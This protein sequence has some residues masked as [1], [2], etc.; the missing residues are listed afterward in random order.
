MVELPGPL[1][2]PVFGIDSKIHYK[3]WVDKETGK[4]NEFRGLLGV[5]VNP[6]DNSSFEKEYETILTELFKSFN[7]PKKRSVFKAHDI[8]QLLSPNENAYKSFCL[9]FARK[10]LSLPDTKLTYFVTRINIEHL[11][12]RKVTIFGEYGTATRQVSTQEFI[13]KISPYYN[14]ICA[15]KLG[16]ITGVKSGMFIF[17][18]TES[19]LPCIAW[20]EFSKSQHLRIVFG[21]DRTIPVIATSDI[22]LR[23]LDFFL[24]ERRGILDESAI[25]EIILHDDIVSADGKFFKYIGNPDLR[26][27]KPL[28]DSALGVNDLKAYVHHPIIFLSAGGT[29]GQ[30]SIVETSPIIEA[31][32]DNAS[33]LHASVKLYDPRKDR[34]M[35][36]SSDVPD[37]FFSF[38]DAAKSQFQ[39]LKRGGKNVKEYD[40]G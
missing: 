35:I 27:I 23:S 25:K 15:W 29:A 14:I 32:Y 37:Y 34:F 7:I 20:Q 3:E 1:T 8:G 36:G 21:G 13:D 10:V 2:G 31:I 18:G 6:K 9:N 12:G 17:D 22:L 16:A 40:L 28:C 26:K 30:K 19:I 38:N 24:Q 11:I 4:K 39:A 5:S 33:S